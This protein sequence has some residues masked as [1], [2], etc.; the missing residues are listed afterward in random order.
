MTLEL[1][2]ENYRYAGWENVVINKSM[3]SIV[4]NFAMSIKDSTEIGL[5]E[6]SNVKVIKDGKVFLSGFF[7]NITVNVGDTKQPMELSGRSRPCDLVDCNIEENKQYNNQNIVQIMEDLVS[8]FNIKVSSSLELEPLELFKTKVG[9]T[10]FDAINRLCKQTNT[11]P[12]STVNGDIEIIKNAMKMSSKILRDGDFKELSFPRVL[13][14]RFSKY[15]Y[16]KESADEDITDGFIEDENVTRFRPFVAVNTEDKTNLDMAEWKKN[17]N[18]AREISLEAKV[19]D[20]WDLEINTLVK[21]ETSF[22]ENIFLI[23]ELTHN[24]GDNGTYTDIVFVDRNLYSDRTVIDNIK[25]YKVK[26]KKKIDKN[27][28]EEEGEIWWTN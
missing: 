8:P 5:T 25:K 2:I 13:K 9:E 28:D 20:G 7:D 21:I 4:D 22:V 11:L 3:D 24:K 17:Y 19:Y 12:I 15:T 6:D 14:E 1:Q 10:Y 23:K 26:K 18:N 27:K 16:R